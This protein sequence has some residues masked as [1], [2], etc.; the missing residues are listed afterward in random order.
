MTS[1]IRADQVPPLAQRLERLIPVV[2]TVL[3]LLVAIMTIT[4]WPIGAFEDDGIYTVLGK[5]LATGEGFRLGNLPGSPN[6]THYPPGYPFVLSL[7]WRI[8]PEFPDNVVIFKFANAVFLALAALGTWYFARRRLAMSSIGAGA[9]AIASTLSIVVLF[10]TGMV[11][12]EPLFLALL[13]PSLLV[14]ERCAD[15]GDLRRAALAGGLLGSL[16]LVRTLGALAIPAVVVLLLLRRHVRA[17]IVL[18]A[19][20]ALFIVPWQIWVGLHQQSLAPVLAGKF[21]AYGPWMSDGYADGG[22]SLIRAVIARNLQ[23]LEGMLGYMLM[24]VRTEWPRVLAFLTLSAFTVLGAWRLARRMPVSVVFFFLYLA[25]VL[26]WPFDANRFLWAV[27]PLVVIAAW[28]GALLIAQGTDPRRFSRVLRVALLGMATAP[29]AGFLVYNVRA[30]R[31]KWWASIQMEAGQQ[32][33]PIVEW[34]ARNTSMSDVIATE[35]DL[36][37]HLY[38]G[39]RAT[40]VSTFLPKHRVQPLTGAEDLEALRTIVEAYEPRFV[41]VSAQPS[42]GSAEALAIATPPILRHVGDL[43]NARIYQRITPS[44]MR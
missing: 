24:P 41:I 37:V 9:V 12:S 17:A 11:L 2:V 8:S 19:M 28:H 5:S 20:A 18:G 7:L 43:P 14:A 32:A 1:P 13:M 34:V 3:V 39:R 27:W 4:P 40:P 35:R 10:V 21:G 33:R 26:V 42:V 38:T 31:G 29:V 23:G 30:Y 6:A 22:W 15:T 16:A 36:V 25:T 44:G